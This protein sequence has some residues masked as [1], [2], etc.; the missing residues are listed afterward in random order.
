M[1]MN[2]FWLC[3]LAAISLFWIW[4]CYY[5]IL[6]DR[7]HEYRWWAKVFA[8][9]VVSFACVVGVCMLCA[10]DASAVM[11]RLRRRLA[12]DGERS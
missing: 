4:T 11:K 1:V 5:V 10:E 7:I 2:W 8:P 12:R 9:P 6:T 3:V